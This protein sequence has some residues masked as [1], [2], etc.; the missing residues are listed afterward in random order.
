MNLYDPNRPQTVVDTTT[1]PTTQTDPNKHPNQQDPATLLAP[2]SASEAHKVY[3]DREQPDPDA[4]LPVQG[5]NIHQ[6]DGENAPE[7][8]PTGDAQGSGSERYAG[9]GDWTEAGRAFDGSPVEKG[10][11][12]DVT[13]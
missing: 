6:E 2:D 13:K 12:A 9:A 4:D 3:H 5:I 10:S 1:Q 7:S 8:L 11:D